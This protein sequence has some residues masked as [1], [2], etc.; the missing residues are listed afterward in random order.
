MSFGF[1]VKSSG[2]RSSCSL[3]S[4]SRPAATAVTTSSPVAA[5]MCVS[6]GGGGSPC[7]NVSFSGLVRLAQL[8]EDV[9]L[10]LVRLLLR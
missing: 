1:G 2:T 5:G 3:S 9:P 4:R 8:G 7:P 10:E 6:L